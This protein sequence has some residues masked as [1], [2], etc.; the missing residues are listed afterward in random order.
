M[1]WALPFGDLPTPTATVLPALPG[2][3][4][5]CVRF[6]QPTADHNQVAGSAGQLPWVRPTVPA[7]PQAEVLAVVW[8]AS[9][10]V[11]EAFRHYLWVSHRH[12]SSS[13]LAPPQPEGHR[14]L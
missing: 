8:V 6:F 4:L 5:G 12:R 3:S 2:S 9:Q 7:H 10:V 14:L 1:K 11:G 13:H